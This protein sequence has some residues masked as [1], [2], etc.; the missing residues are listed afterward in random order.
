MESD[1]NWNEDDKLNEIEMKADDIFYGFHDKNINN[2]DEETW[3]I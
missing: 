2:E 3:R 1:G